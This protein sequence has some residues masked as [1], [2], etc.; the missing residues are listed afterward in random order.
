MNVQTQV[1]ATSSTFY[2]ALGNYPDILIPTVDPYHNQITNAWPTTVA[3]GKNQSA[4]VDVHIPSNAPAGY[5]LGSVTVK[6]G[7]VTLTNMP[8]I[9]GVWQWPSGGHMPSTSSLRSAIPTGYADAC[10]QFYRGYSGCGAYPGANGNPDLGVTLS[11]VDENILLLDH[12][13]SGL[14]F[15]YPPYTTTFTGLETYY[16]PL[17][18][19]TAPTMLSGARSTAAS[20]GGPGA[21]NLSYIQNWISEFAKNGWS[22]TLLDYNVD[23]PHSTADWARLNSNATSIHSSTPPMPSLVTTQIYDATQN[24]SL[25]S[26]DWMVAVINCLDIAGT[27]SYNSCGPGALIG[28][29]R[30]TYNSWLSGKCCGS[31]SP[32]RQL[33]SYQACSS[34]G[35]CSNGTVGN[36]F[37]TFPNYDIDGVSAANRVMEWLT[38]LH[39]ETGELYYDDTYSWTSGNPWNSVY[40]FGGWGDGTLFY[41]STSGTSNYVTQPGGS[42]LAHPT[43]LPSV[44]LKHMRDGMQDYEYLTAITSNGQGIIVQQQIANWITNSYTFETSGTGLQIARL[45]LGW[46]LHHF[47][48]PAMVMP[49]SGLV[50]TVN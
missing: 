49:P 5:Y 9:I 1:T 6:S 8:V 44:R 33:W 24:N 30:P 46:V 34:A 26:I 31:G 23:E 4:W 43:Y 13:F 22:A 18:N 11:L 40:D 14:G 36:K 45:H 29:Q 47:T 28:N 25:N 15:I 41:P 17:L 27:S 7:T 37:N 16:G 12:R 2:G 42:Q 48:F 3:A 38:F 20:Y 50:T 21:Q 10:I 35:T 32:T 39:S 19:G